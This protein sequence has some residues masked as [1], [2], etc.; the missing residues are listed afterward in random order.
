MSRKRKASDKGK[1]RSLTSRKTRFKDV[2]A[3]QFENTS[4]HREVPV[5]SAEPPKAGFETQ[6]PRR[7]REM[8]RAMQIAKDREAGKQVTWRAHR[9]D[10]PRPPHQARQKKKKRKAEA[11]A[12]APESAE[13][14]SAAGPSPHADAASATGEG[15]ARRNNKRQRTADSTSELSVA[16]VGRASPK[17][18][19]AAGSKLEFVRSKRTK[20]GETNTAPPDIRVGGQLRKKLEQRSAAAALKANEVA[21]QREAAIQAY[22]AA[23]AARREQQRT[24]AG[25]KG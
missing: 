3:A 10:L 22:A 11:D 6:V 7:M 21:R 2:S 25:G 24:D 20:F 1:S 19:Q 15:T 17:H 8:Q 4:F 16:A 12:P 13:G 23:K 5:L 18:A 14:E 9:E